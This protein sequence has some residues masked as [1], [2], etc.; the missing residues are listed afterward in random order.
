MRQWLVCNVSKKLREQQE[1]PLLYGG[2]GLTGT[3]VGMARG[4]IGWRM[5]TDKHRELAFFHGILSRR[6]WWADIR[7]GIKITSRS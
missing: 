4:G 7:A 1:T 3:M 5:V 6:V 2:E